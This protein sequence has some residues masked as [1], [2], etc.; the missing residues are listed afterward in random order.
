MILVSQVIKETQ[1]FLESPAVLDIL[2]IKEALA[3]WD[4]QVRKQHNPF[5]D[6]NRHH[7]LNRTSTQICLLFPRKKVSIVEVSSLRLRYA[8]WPTGLD[9]LQFWLNWF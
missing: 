6:K 9:A 1:V 7:P 4:I 8:N 3:K 5:T 2:E